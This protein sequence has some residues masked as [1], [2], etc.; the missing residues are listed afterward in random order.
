MISL[1]KNVCIDKLYNIIDNYNNT[2]HKTI[3]IK[4]FLILKEAHKSILM[5]K[6]TTSDVLN[7]RLVIMF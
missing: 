1:S 2:Y 7:L 5:L 6:L 3:K 4:P